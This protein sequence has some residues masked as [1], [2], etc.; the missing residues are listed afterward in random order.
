MTDKYSLKQQYW[1]ACDAYV[2]AFCE[3]HGY[4]FDDARWVSDRAGG[5]AEVC[6][7]FVDMATIMDDIDLDVP[8]EEFVRWYDYTLELRSIG[9]QTL[10]NFRSWVKGCPRMSEQDIAEL[11]A[12]HQNVINA[13]KA[14]KEAINNLKINNHEI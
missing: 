6:D 2:F 7:Y 9:V 12:L 10:P 1:N 14:L 3:K 4:N 11:R 13:E 5:I 8:E